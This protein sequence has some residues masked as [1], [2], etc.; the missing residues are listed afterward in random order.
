VAGDDLLLREEFVDF[1][2]MRLA[3]LLLISGKRAG[4][5]TRT[6]TSGCANR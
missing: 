1:W 4:D 5:R 2:T 3:D 6:I